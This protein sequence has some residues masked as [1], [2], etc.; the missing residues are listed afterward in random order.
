MTSCVPNKGT[1]ESTQTKHKHPT[2][3]THTEAAGNKGR[4]GQG[5]S[6]R[7]KILS[8][9]PHPSRGSGAAGKGL[10]TCY[11]PALLLGS[12]PAGAGYFNPSQI[13]FYFPNTTGL[14]RGA[15]VRIKCS[16]NIS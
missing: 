2:A 15:H 1:L 10:W 12:D 16:I 13:S 8:T 14:S 4:T 11:P 3:D 6:C 7:E 5:G 9:K